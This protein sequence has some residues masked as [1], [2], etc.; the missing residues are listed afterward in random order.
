MKLALGL[1]EYVDRAGFGAGKLDGL[2]DDGLKHG[3]QIKR[4]IDRLTDLAE[5]PQL[6]NQLTKLVGTFT[7]RSQEPR[8]FDGDDG[9]GGKVLDQIDLFVGERLY[10]LAVDDDAPDHLAIPEHRHADH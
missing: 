5:S 9:L 2:A 3:V 10:F 1:V 6:L 8:I 4:G 7:Q